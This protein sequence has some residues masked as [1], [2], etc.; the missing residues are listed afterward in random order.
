MHDYGCVYTV[1]RQCSSIHFLENIRV[2]TL[3]LSARDD[4]FHP[5]EVLDEVTA[6]A[7]T[8]RLLTLD[9]PDRGGHVG[10]VGGY[11]PWQ[12]IDYAELR[13]LAFMEQHL[14]EASGESRSRAV[15]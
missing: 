13:V 6:I 15:C 9:F 3:L 5:P 2:P 11:W 14:I 10:F 7:R 1:A 12:P 4:P 8:N